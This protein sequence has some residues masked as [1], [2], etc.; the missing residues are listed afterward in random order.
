M[1]SIVTG[2]LN[3]LGLLPELLKN[4]IYSSDLVELILIDG[5]STDGTL[6]YLDNI[7]HHNLVVIKY[8]N[9]SFYPEFM[10]LGISKAKYPYI[11]QWNDDILL[12]TTWEKVKDCIDDTHD[13]YNFPYPNQIL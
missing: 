1:F 9:R 8:G 11:V 4:T 3:R 10:N 12:D 7:V 6:E 2:T 5:G 13:L